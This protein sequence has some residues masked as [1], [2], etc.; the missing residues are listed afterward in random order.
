MSHEAAWARARV[1][2]PCGHLETLTL[3]G[4]PERLRARRACWEAA[5]G[6][7]A[8]CWGAE[9]FGGPRP[10]VS[11][12]LPLAGAGAPRVAPGA[13]VIARPEDA[14]RALASGAGRV[15]VVGGREVRVETGGPAV[16][17]VAPGGRAVVGP[18]LR[19]VRSWGSTRV[20][21][22]GVVAGGPGSVTRVQGGAAAAGDRARLVVFSGRAVAGPGAMA[23][24]SPGG[25]DLELWVLPG[26]LVVGVGAPRLVTSPGVLGADGR[27]VG[28]RAPAGL[29]GLLGLAELLEVR[30][31]S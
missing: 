16:V 12:A 28:G 11:G 29:L 31:L 5:R 7:C 26:A 25:R 1:V 18:T 22:G 24:L 10:G 21:A 15:E 14:V 13:V 4:L 6:S 30:R 19:P 3:T 2:R 23:A 9:A 20:A 17:S 8:A 27:Q